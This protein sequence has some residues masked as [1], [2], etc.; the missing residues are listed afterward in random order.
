MA[1][2]PIAEYRPLLEAVAVEMGPGWVVGTSPHVLR[3]P[4]V[5]TDGTVALSIHPDDYGTA[6]ARIGFSGEGPADCAALAQ[7]AW[8]TGPWPS[9]TVAATRS[10]RAIARQLLR[11]MVPAMAVQASDFAA[12]RIRREAALTAHSEFVAALVPFG[13]DVAARAAAASSSGCGRHDYH[14]RIDVG[15]AS[16]EVA[17]SF[18]GDPWSATAVGAALTLNGLTPMQVLNALTAI[19]TNQLAAVLGALTAQPAA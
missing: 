13:A 5:L 8:H 7:F 6:P 14:A 4:A 16:G 12:A 11:I 9:T 1:Y 19:E 3:N 18:R 15:G 17:V 10:P 2:D